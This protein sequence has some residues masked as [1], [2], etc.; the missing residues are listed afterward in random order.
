MLRSAVKYDILLDDINC[1]SKHTKQGNRVVTTRSFKL[2]EREPTSNSCYIIRSRETKYQLHTAVVLIDWPL[3]PCLSF[4][5]S[6]LAG[7]G[8]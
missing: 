2:Q 5:L 4:L 6:I 7:W 3:S 8:Q 1:I